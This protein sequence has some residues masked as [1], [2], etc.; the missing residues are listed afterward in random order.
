MKPQP[1]KV[2]GFKHFEQSYKKTLNEMDEKKGRTFQE[3]LFTHGHYPKIHQ[4]ILNMMY[5]LRINQGS[6]K[7]NGQGTLNVMYRGESIIH[8][9]NTFAAS[10]G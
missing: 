4:K 6:I 8:P 2:S 10:L 3:C 9:L 7:L 1:L 5:F